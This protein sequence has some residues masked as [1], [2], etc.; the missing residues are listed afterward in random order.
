MRA[1]LIN[2]M[3]KKKPH[4]VLRLL[5]RLGCPFVDP[6]KYKN[7]Y[8]ARALCDRQAKVGRDT[9]RPCSE[10]P[11]LCVFNIGLYEFYVRIL[12]NNKADI[13]QR[14]QGNSNKLVTIPGPWP[15]RSMSHT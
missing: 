5:L 9:I 11:V 12:H 7:P 10:S 14:F 4:L 2:Y 1:F 13:G 15:I 8:N 6:E 3:K